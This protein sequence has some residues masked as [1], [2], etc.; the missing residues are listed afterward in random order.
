MGWQGRLL[1]VGGPCPKP[2]LPNPAT[3]GGEAGGDPGGK[4]GG[5][6]AAAAG[7]ARGAMAGTGRAVLGLAAVPSHSRGAQLPRKASSLHELNFSG[8]L[9]EAG[10]LNLDGLRAF[11]QRCYKTFIVAE[12]EVRMCS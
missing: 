8:G 4:A 3:M 10:G 1:R 2:R 9:Q 7:G 12:D 5:S 6:G 11:A